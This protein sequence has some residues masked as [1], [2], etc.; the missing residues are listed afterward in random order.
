MQSFSPWTCSCLY[1]VLPSASL[2]WEDRLLCPSYQ[3]GIID[4]I[5][6]MS[7]LP[8]GRSLAVSIALRQVTCPQLWSAVTLF[9]STLLETCLPLPK[10]SQ[11]EESSWPLLSVSHLLQMFALLFL[12]GLGL[13]LQ[14]GLSREVLPSLDHLPG[15]VFLS[16]RLLLKCAVVAL[17]R[18]LS[19]D[20][21]FPLIG[22]LGKNSQTKYGWNSKSTQPLKN[23][24]MVKIQRATR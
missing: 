20:L 11:P 8:P 10:L 16:A 23:T 15:P 3:R 5:S 2:V 12:H 18:W 6:E 17:R 19:L 7:C 21:V 1:E 14:A 22:S 4:F 9:P 24:F 13:Q